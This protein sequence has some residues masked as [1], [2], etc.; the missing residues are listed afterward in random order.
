MTS[1]S[2]RAQPAEGKVAAPPPG[3]REKTLPA[4]DAD[5]GAKAENK[6]VPGPP[7]NGPAANADGANAAA[8]SPVPAAASSEAAAAQQ[9]GDETV[10]PEET[11]K[12]KQQR[13]AEKRG[14]IAITGGLL[15]GLASQAA[16][17]T[18]VLVYFGWVRTNATYGYFGVD[19]SA[20]SFSV[21]D[22]VLRSVDAAFPMLVVIGLIATCA[23]VGHEQLRPKLD[24]DPD[25]VRRVVTW[26]GWGGVALVLAGLLLALALTGPNGSDIWGPVVLMV[27][28]AATAYAFGLRNSRTPNGGTAY[29]AAVLGMTLVAFLWTV[30]AYAGYIGVQKADQVT[31]ELATQADVTVYSTDSLPISGPGIT[32]S[33]IQVP[34]SE[35]HFRY[36]G[37]RLLVSS[38]GQ[39]F[40]LPSRWRQG[41]GPVIALPVTDP[42]IL[43]EF[44]VTKPAPAG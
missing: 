9:H 38:G 42:G 20:L 32:T 29:L 22:Y 40:L 37:L 11:Q 43:V 8:A 35:Y 10:P 44:T 16:V 30:T 34:Q 25:L 33:Q 15:A 18:A 28:F 36:G 41:D 21:P 6:A 3:P 1:G 13:A 17:L 31:A 4:I 19:V 24:K 2:L 26:A 27:G 23:M 12:Q 5:S 14:L 7:D 39:Y